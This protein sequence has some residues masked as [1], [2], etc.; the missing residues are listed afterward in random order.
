MI[1]PTSIDGTD[2]TGAT[3]DGTDVQ[4][5]T[6]DGDVV[7]SASQIPNSVIHEYLFDEGV[8]QTVNDSVGNQDISTNFANWVSDPD[9]EGGFA[10]Q[11]DGVNDFGQSGT[12]GSFGADMNTDFAVEL[13]LS[14]TSNG[15]ILGVVNSAD[16]TVLA[17]NTFTTFD[18]AND[19]LTC[20]TRSSNDNSDFNSIDS[21]IDVT[22]GNL[23]HIIW[24]KVTNDPN[25]WEIQ[26]NGNDRTGVVIRANFK[27]NE[28]T[29][30]DNPM[31]YFG[32]SNAVNSVISLIQ[33]EI[34]VVRWYDDSLS[35]SELNSLWQQQPFS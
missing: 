4:E 19:K 28:T 23:L 10:L 22:T 24:N 34:A 27:A 7:F 29:N 8:G 11:A 1:P 12:M 6:V 31:G 35:S 33:G 9:Y 3:I 17:L 15:R 21:T 16:E 30:F 32:L 14:T 5:I 2:I 26:I 18:G 25:N 13:V 20:V